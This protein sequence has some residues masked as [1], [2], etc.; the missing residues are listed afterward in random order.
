M[1][2]MAKTY[3]DYFVK[4]KLTKTLNLKTFILD[5]KKMSGS[6]KKYVFDLHNKAFDSDTYAKILCQFCR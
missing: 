3:N 2:S 1:I 4:N 6:E 5:Q